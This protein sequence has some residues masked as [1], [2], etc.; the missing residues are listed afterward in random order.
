MDNFCG[1]NVETLNPYEAS[2]TIDDKIKKIMEVC[3]PHLLVFDGCTIR[4]NN[5]P[6]AAL[7]GVKQIAE[8]IQNYIFNSQLSK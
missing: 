2:I 7:D 8:Q 4:N 5:T 1:M 6:G 3:C